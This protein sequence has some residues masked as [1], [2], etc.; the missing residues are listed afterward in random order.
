MQHDE[1]TLIDFTRLP[2]LCKA[3]AMDYQSLNMP[4]AQPI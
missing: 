2:W 1:K 4:E 3:I